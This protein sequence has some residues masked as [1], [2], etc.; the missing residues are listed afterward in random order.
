MSVRPP[1]GRPHVA[2]EP[3]VC[4]CCDSGDSTVEAVGPDYDCHT[5]GDQ[6]FTLVQCAKCSTYYLNPRPTTAMLPQIYA[7]DDY[8]SYSS[9][10]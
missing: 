9:A 8:Y 2:L 1:A 6:T 3:V 5:C 10:E 4:P 7:A